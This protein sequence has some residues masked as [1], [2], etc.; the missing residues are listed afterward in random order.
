MNDIVITQIDEPDQTVVVRVEEDIVALRVFFGDPRE[1]PNQ[2]DVLLGAAG[3]E[4][5]G[6]A[7]I[8]AATHAREAS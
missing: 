1:E 7:L 5:L 2:F 4:R 8:L 3:A 6:G